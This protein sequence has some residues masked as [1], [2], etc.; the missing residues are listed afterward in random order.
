ME[1]ITD[2]HAQRVRIDFERKKLGG[3]H[4]LYDQ[5]HTFLLVYVFDNVTYLC[6]EIYKLDPAKFLLAPG[7]APALKRPK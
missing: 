6:L 5:M 1:D 2:A 4:D 7:L 3:Y